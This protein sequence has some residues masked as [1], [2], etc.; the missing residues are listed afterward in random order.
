M[1]AVVIT[2]GVVLLLA[3]LVAAVVVPA[4]LAARQRQ[5]MELEIRLARWQLQ[6]VTRRAMLTMLDAARRP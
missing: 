4:T 3:A 1:E 5:R 2:I 6:V